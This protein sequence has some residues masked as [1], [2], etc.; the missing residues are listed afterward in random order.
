VTPRQR[1]P[2]FAEVLLRGSSVESG[3]LFVD[4]VVFTPD[5]VAG[6]LA[7]HGLDGTSCT[8]STITADGLGECRALLA[9]A[10]GDD[11]DFFFVLVPRRFLLYADHDEYVTLFTHKRGE[12]AR[13][14]EAL[15]GDGVKEVAGFTRK[16]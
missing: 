6:V 9:A 7:A 13:L 14:S 15:I 11:I 12:L 16:L 5:R 10:L 8:G 1:L 3:Y 2:A 4:T